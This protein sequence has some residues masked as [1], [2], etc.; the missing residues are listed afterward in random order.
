MRS[1]AAM[2]AH[3]NTQP[4]LPNTPA[5]FNRSSQPSAAEQSNNY[6]IKPV[7]Q[8]PVEGRS[9]ERRAAEERAAEERGLIDTIRQ[10]KLV[11]V[12]VPEGLA[13]AVQMLQVCA[14]TRCF[15]YFCLSA[16]LPQDLFLSC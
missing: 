5:P 9:V 11:G 16:C 6:I 12:D 14:L 10:E 4:P 7:S 15:L 3:P 8:Q 1:L 2:T 13:G